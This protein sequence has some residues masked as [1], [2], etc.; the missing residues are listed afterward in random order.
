[1]DSLLL[2]LLLCFVTMSGVTWHAHRLGN[3]RRD[4]KLLG[5]LAAVLGAS[6]AVT[7]AM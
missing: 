7:A 6:A 3:D 2:L 1:M 5:G 4:V